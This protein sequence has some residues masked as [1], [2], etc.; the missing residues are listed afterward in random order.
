MLKRLTSLFPVFWGHWLSVVGSIATTVAAN[1][2]LVFFLMD[3]TRGLNPYSAAV[4]YMILPIFFVGGLVLVALGAWRGGKRPGAEARAS[5][6]LST[7]LQAITVDPK[8]RKRLMAFG[9]LTGINIAIVTIATYKG[10]TYTSTPS[11]CGQLCHQTMEPEHTVY[12]DSPHARIPCADCH[13][14]HGIGPFF[15]SKLA[16]ARQLWHMTTGDIPRPIPTPVHGLRPARETCEKCHWPAKFSGYRMV[17]HHKYADDEQNS[18]TTDVVQLHVGGMNRRTGKYEGIHWH[19]NKGVKITYEA[20]NKERAVIGKVTVER[21]GKT[22]VFYPPKTYTDPKTEKDIPFPTKVVETRVMDCVDCHNRPTHVYARSESMAIDRAMALGKINP[23]LPFVKKQSLALLKDT[24]APRR[25]A[26]KRYAA[27]LA[28]FYAQKYPQVAKDKATQI[29][30]AGEEL[31]R[32][33]RKNIWPRMN[34]R[35]GTYPNH[36]GHRGTSE[37]CFRCHDDEHATKEEEYISQ[38]CDTCHDLLADD[39][40]KPDVPEAVLKLG[41][42]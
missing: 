27:K 35:W 30:Y 23:S 38:D 40:A 33:Y 29:R 15:E 19:V 9:L 31:G 42:R 20:M 28:Q 5:S 24:S 7:A 2:F 16:G 18:R 39:E 34:I 11:F 17:V 22:T 12:K 25:D 37:G 41:Q 1:A 8:T 4:A 36:L 6:R 10:V 21:A 32:I 26:G 13:V 14:G 3:M